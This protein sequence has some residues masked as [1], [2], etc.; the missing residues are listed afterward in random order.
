MFPDASDAGHVFEPDRFIES[1]PIHAQQFGGFL[2]REKRRR[3]VRSNG[4]V[5]M[6]GLPLA[7]ARLSGFE[8]GPHS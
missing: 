7:L 2:H 3:S 5:L 4:G 8:E 6:A 1:L